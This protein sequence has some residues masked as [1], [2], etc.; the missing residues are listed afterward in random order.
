MRLPILAAAA[1]LSAGA[2]MAAGAAGPALADPA[3]EIRDAVA[4]VVVIPEARDD[5]KV[6]VLKARQALPLKVEQKGGRT[7]ID[8]GLKNRLR[9]CGRHDGQASATV[10]GVG[11]VGWNDMPQIVVRTPM[12]ATVRAGGAVFGAVGR[13]RSLDLAS[14][15]CGD[16]TVAN[17]EGMLRLSSAGSGKV[18]AGSAGQAVLR[19]A[20]SADMTVGEVGGQL[21]VDLAGSGDVHVRSAA[22]AV[23]VKI[24]GSGDVEIA[25]GRAGAVSVLIAGSGDLEFG[26]AAESLKARVLGSGDVHVDR[27]TGPVE[28]SVMGSG[29]ITVGD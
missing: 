25:W 24:A 5:V 7:V 2:V 19:L 9:G 17:T 15:G 18:R 16:W 12:A 27:V 3:V 20:G 11:E 10:A 21:G 1:T 22:G 8:G 23:D 4:R 14:G 26:G 28:R 13:S 6:E 29:Q